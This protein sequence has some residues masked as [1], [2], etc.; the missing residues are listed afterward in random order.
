[1]IDTTLC[2]FVRRIEK[3]IFFKSFFA[4]SFLFSF[5]WGG[6]L[7]KHGK[8]KIAQRGAMLELLVTSWMKVSRESRRTCQEFIYVMEGI[9]F[10]LSIN[11][12]QEF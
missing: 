10:E 7:D 1:M 4:F 6:G 12:D 2:G 5:F 9:I 11:V 8:S 3:D